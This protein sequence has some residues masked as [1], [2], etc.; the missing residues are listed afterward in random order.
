MTKADNL[1]ANLRDTLTLYIIITNMDNLD[2]N[3]SALDFVS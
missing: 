3:S 2:K 1:D